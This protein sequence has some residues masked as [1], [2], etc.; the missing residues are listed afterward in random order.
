MLDANLIRRAL[1]RQSDHAVANL[2]RV[3]EGGRAG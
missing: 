3:L 1:S 2:K